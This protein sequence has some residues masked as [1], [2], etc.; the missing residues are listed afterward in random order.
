MRTGRWKITEVDYEAL[1]SRLD[2]SPSRLLFFITIGTAF[3]SQLPAKDVGHRIQISGERL[4]PTFHG[5]LRQLFH[6]LSEGD[7]SVGDPGLYQL[8]NR[9]F[10]L[11][12]GIL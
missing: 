12:L 6:S 3:Q 2:T 1:V 11:F 4:S 9:G 7:Q 10:D 5:I 8:G